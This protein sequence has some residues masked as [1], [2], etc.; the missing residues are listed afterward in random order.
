MPATIYLAGSRPLAF[1]HDGI[2]DC[3]VHVGKWYFDTEGDGTLRWV[4]GMNKDF[5]ISRSVVMIGLPENIG[6]A[7]AN[8]QLLDEIGGDDRFLFFYWIDPRTDEI[9]TLESLG[10]RIHGLKLHPSHTRTRVTDAKAG[11]FLEWCERNR[12]PMLV[13]C[14]RWREYSDYRFVIESASRYGFPFIMAHMGGP[15]YELKVEALDALAKAGLDNVFLD[16][17]TCFQPHLIRKA[18][19]VVGPSRLLF[20]SDYPLYH[21]AL[22]VQSVLL[23]GLSD[24]DTAGILGD[25]IS[26]LMRLRGE[27]S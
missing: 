18:L 11:P 1:A 13:H 25:S 9:S 16:T 7:Q 20:G 10:N 24:E 2:I 21:P 14:G 8:E 26:R 15:A 22:S 27:R 23:A 17:S 19:K 5:G 4:H 12:K 3:H 6:N